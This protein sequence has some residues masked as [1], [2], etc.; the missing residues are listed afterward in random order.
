MAQRRMV[1]KKISINESI[2][3]L[4]FAGQ[5]LFT[6]MIPHADDLGLLPF[7][8]RSIK[9]LVVPMWDETADEIG[10][11]LESIWKTGVIE[12][13]EINGEKFIHLKSFEENQTLKRDRQPQTILS[14]KLKDKPKESWSLLESIWKTHGVI[15]FPFG[16]QR[17][18]EEKGREENLS[19][20]KRIE[21]T[22]ATL[23]ENN[24]PDKT[25]IGEI[26]KGRK[27]FQIPS[28]RNDG[29]STEWQ[30]R[31]FNY[32]DDLGIKLESKNKPRWLK[33]FK[34]AYEGRKPGNLT[35]AYA[36]CKDH[37]KWLDMNNEERM[38]MIFYLYENGLKENFNFE[39]G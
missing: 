30:L 15:E 1:N 12:V 11:L 39:R 10:N 24:T 36:Y 2:A 16:N 20:E 33:V 32:A 37:P 28:K 31:A 29:V 19:E 3:G 17:L 5:L 6:W 8:P 27:Y 4:S 22:G 35:N 21:V 14:V 9:A 18:P 38:N 26:L 7:S 25:S 23:P 34:Q 13:V